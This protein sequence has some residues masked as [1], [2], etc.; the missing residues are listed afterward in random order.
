ME[1]KINRKRAFIESGGG[2]LV[3]GE[4]VITQTAAERVSQ[5]KWE[6]IGIKKK[7]KNKPG[8]DGHFGALWRLLK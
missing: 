5:S 3:W 8:G 2:S 4:F 6:K 7:Y 1:G